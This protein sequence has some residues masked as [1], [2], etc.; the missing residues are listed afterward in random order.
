MAK[1]KLV[2]YGVHLDPEDVARIQEHTP[3][4]VPERAFA[5]YVFGLGLRTLTWVNQLDLRELPPPP[6]RR[7]GGKR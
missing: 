3:T 7:A 1:R 6:A 2:L 5:R 4:G